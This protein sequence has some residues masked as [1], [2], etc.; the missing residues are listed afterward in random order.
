M[1][2]VRLINGHRWEP[3]LDFYHKRR[4]DQSL[5]YNIELQYVYII[6]PWIQ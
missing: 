4:E 5:R 2:N 3:N 6:V 1:K